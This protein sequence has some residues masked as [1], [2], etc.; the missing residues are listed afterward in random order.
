MM[1]EGRRNVV[2][3]EKVR[4]V[5]E[6]KEKKRFYSTGCKKHKTR[7]AGCAVGFSCESWWLK[8][9]GGSEN[10]FLLSHDGSKN[11]A[12]ENEAFSGRVKID[13]RNR[14]SSQKKWNFE[15]FGCQAKRLKFGV[16]LF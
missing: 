11:E 7:G 9:T 5:E 13:V 14:M 4:S 6:K 12:R 1:R 16:F 2:G 15:S 8:K 3:V 10:A